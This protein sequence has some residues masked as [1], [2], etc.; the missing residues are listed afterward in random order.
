MVKKV[1]LGFSVALIGV[2]AIVA[3]IGAMTGGGEG[4]VLASGMAMIFWGVVIVAVTYL[5][6]F[7]WD[8]IIGR[9]NR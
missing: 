4:S 5:I 2:G 9:P 8:S 7:I 3:L 1:V 6:S